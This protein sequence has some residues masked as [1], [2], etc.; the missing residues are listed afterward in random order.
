MER[1]F[2]NVIKY[3]KLI[4]ALFIIAAIVSAGL[5]QMVGVNYNLYEYLPEDSDSSV[6]LDVMAEEFGG[7]I[8]NARVMISDISVPEAIEYKERMEKVE[9]V[10]EVAW[11]DDSFDITIPFSMADT[12]EIEKSYTK[13]SALYSL[14]VN[15]EYV[16]TAIAEIRGIIGDDNCM[17]GSAVSTAVATDSTVDEIKRL[18]VMSIIA[19]ILILILS[20]TSW[21]EPFI[22]LLGIGLAVLINAGTNIIF[23]EI[24]FVTNAAGSILQLAVSL[25]YSVFLIHR[26]REMRAIEPDNEKALVG[27]LMKS[28]RSILSSG[29]TTIIGFSALCLMRY[30]IGPD[31]G[32]AL[33]KG[34]CISLLMVFIFMPGILYSSCN[35]IDR[36]S[37]VKFTPD[38]RKLGKLVSKVTIPL[39]ICFILIIVPSYMASTSNDFYF[40]ASHIFEEGTQYGD[41]TAKIRDE[42]GKKDTYVL[43]VP[44]ESTATETRLIADIKELP[45]VESITA[46]AEQAGAEIPYEYLDEE[47]LSKLESDHYSRIVIGVVADYEGDETTDLIDRIREIAEAY[48]ND[49]YYLAGEGVSTYDLKNT[50]MEDMIKVNLM[51]VGAV[52]LILVLTMRSLMLP[53]ILVLTIET[54][55]WINLSMYYYM[56]QPL[57]YIA[58]LI[59]S[60]IQL[61]A[62]VDYAILFT[63]RYRENREELSR[64][65]CIIKT[66][67]DTTISILT[68]GTAIAGVGF[69]LGKL[70]SHELLSQLGFLLGKGSIFSVLAVLFV[71]PGF[72]YMADRFVLKKKGKEAL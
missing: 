15:K 36:T 55:I 8:P 58:Y 21:I 46:F 62:T 25:D 51:A 66:I 23:G 27:A 20:T 32:L 4:I 43:M 14:T 57:F 37:H 18:A 10:E 13:G 49:G 42:F 6:A 33:A 47:T 41:D 35:L 65:E 3:R 70:T 44:K 60:S 56:S 54:A 72:L 39:S 69:L 16:N 38:C 53:V 64:K 1:F 52:F 45:Q 29:L 5:R 67:S 2:S 28:G 22:I 50:V 17:T 12:S 11:L 59:I 24:S 19:A 34:I 61:G 63:D 40:G 26:M 68:S 31:L 48:Y 71:L 30:G 9:G 7:N